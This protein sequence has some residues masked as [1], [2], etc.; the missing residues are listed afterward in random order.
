MGWGASRLVHLAGEALLGTHWSGR[1]LRQ[2]GADAPGDAAQLWRRMVF[3]ILISNTEDHLRNQ[4]FLREPGG[5]RLAEATDHGQ[6]A[7]VHTSACSFPQRR[8]MPNRSPDNLDGSRHD[9]KGVG[10]E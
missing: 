1:H 3:N 9:R 2:D 7:G 5:W 4:G 6:D 10:P 8:R